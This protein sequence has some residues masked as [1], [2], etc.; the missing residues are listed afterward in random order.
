[1]AQ[2]ELNEVW[3]VRIYTQEQ[4][5][6]GINVL[7]YRVDSITGVAATDA[8]L[9]ARMD[10]LFGP[11]MTPLMCSAASYRGIGVQRVNPGPPTVEVYANAEEGD[12]EVAGD[13]L[14]KQTCGIITKRTPLAGRRFRGR[15]YVPFPSEA[16]NDTDANP[17]AGY[18][19]ALAALAGQVADIVLVGTLPST[20][21]MTPVIYHRS[22]QTTTDLVSCSVNDR[23]ATQRRRGDYGRTNVSPI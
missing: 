19:A 5:Q 2:V 17:V 11:L 23:W 18:L 4:A 22:T 9:A 21:S 6:L 12:G 10:L 8:Q 15:M 13:P 3:Q 7:H 20:S 14:P 1:M 16:S